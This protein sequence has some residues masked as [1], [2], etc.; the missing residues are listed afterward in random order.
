[1]RNVIPPSLFPFFLAA[2]AL[3]MV[4]CGGAKPTNCLL[5]D[6]ADQLDRPAWIR[7][8]VPEAK[9][10]P[11]QCSVNADCGERPHAEMTCFHDASC[12]PV[13]EKHWGDCNRD[14]RDGCEEA[15]EHPV[16]CAG[17]P[18]IAEEA[19]SKPLVE[20][21][22]REQSGGHGSFDAPTLRRGLARVEPQLL[23]CYQGVLARAP[24]LEG[25]LSYRLT[26]GERGCIAAKLF[27]GDVRSQ[28]LEACVLAALADVRLPAG[29]RGGTVTFPCDVILL[30]GK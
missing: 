26:L 29:P 3:H 19:S 27:A 24:E 8:A 10:D 9:V 7:P 13:C 14:Y 11:P 22:L 5:P 17:D 16:Y 2:L 6:A 1:M 18:R 21:S 15:I 20:F 25:K 30:N 12:M 23:A 28:D 4:A